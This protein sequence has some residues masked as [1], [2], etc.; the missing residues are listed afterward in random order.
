MNFRVC[1]VQSQ[2]LVHLLAAMRTCAAGTKHPSAQ[3]VTVNKQRA[4]HLVKHCRTE[5]QNSVAKK[6]QS[7]SKGH[8]G[9]TYNS[10][11]AKRI[12]V[13]L[14][15]PSTTNR[16]NL[17]MA[18]MLARGPLSG[19]TVLQREAKRKPPRLQRSNTFFGETS[20]K[21]RA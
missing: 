21:T 4:T 8:M 6:G 3:R 19:F 1:S 13:S 2:P 20:T 14:D 15:K 17:D 9:I 7:S 5:T 16:R 10:D 11:S 18:P 12:L